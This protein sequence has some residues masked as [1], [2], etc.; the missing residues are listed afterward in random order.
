MGHTHST[1]V[2]TSPGGGAGAV[3]AAA[4][5]PPAPCPPRA[6][7]R[8]L[9][10]PRWR[11]RCLSVDQVASLRTELA[12][13][14]EALAVTF[15][16]GSEEENEKQAEEVASEDHEAEASART[17]SSALLRDPMAE[18]ARMLLLKP[19]EE[20]HL[21]GYRLGDAALTSPNLPNLPSF[22]SAVSRHTRL[23]VLDLSFNNLTPEVLVP[24]LD[25]IRDLPL[26]T[27]LK[28]SGNMF[29]SA[30]SDDDKDSVN[31][32]WD[33][34]TVG[35]DEELSGDATASARLGR[36]LATNP[37]L[38]ELALFHCGLNDRD[39][40]DLL[41]GL[42]HPRNTTLHT[43]QLSWNLAC[44]SRSAAMA[45]QLV[46]DLGN[47]VLRELE[48]EGVA[49]ATQV[50][51]EYA[52]TSDGVFRSGHTL[53]RESAG[54][55]AATGDGDNSSSSSTDTASARVATADVVSLERLRQQQR[56]LAEI[57]KR[58]T[59]AQG[60]RYENR[61][62]YLTEDLDGSRV[63]DPLVVRELEAV[64]STR[65]RPQAP[66]NSHH[67][68]SELSVAAFAEQ[69]M[70]S[71]SASGT[72]AQ[73]PDNSGGEFVM[74]SS[75][76]ESGD[77]DPHSGR[78]V[79][80]PVAIA[81]SAA[82]HERQSFEAA[83]AATAMTH[84]HARR[85]LSSP[86]ATDGPRPHT[87]PPMHLR[88][89]Q[90]QQHHR[91]PQEL[92]DARFETPRR[93][94]AVIADAE[95]FRRR[96]RPM[97]LD[98]HAPPC[99]E[100]SR[101]RSGAH[102]ASAAKGQSLWYAD[103]GF[104]LRPNGLTNVLVAPVL[105]GGMTAFTNVA[106]EDVED[107]SL[108]PCW[109]TP[110]QSSPLT[111]I[112]AGTLHY[113]CVHEAT[114]QQQKRQYGTSASSP[115][116]AAATA[117]KPAPPNASKTRLPLLLS[118]PSQE[119][120]EESLST[121][122]VYRG[123]QGTGHRCLS[124]C[125]ASKEGGA[126]RRRHRMQSTLHAKA[127]KSVCKAA[128]SGPDAPASRRLERPQERFPDWTATENDAADSLFNSVAAA[129]SSPL[130]LSTVRTRC[131]GRSMALSYSPAEHF[132]APHVGCASGMK[133]AEF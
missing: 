110:R 14:V 58:L 68:A 74:P 24:L 31:E 105:P 8:P 60:T 82:R 29:G 102:S 119:Q 34:S 63:L 18:E 116:V 78:A 6:P 51:L 84:D 121:A 125:V 87:S 41:A 97:Q 86:K 114:S 1:S 9:M 53:I 101:T 90:Q 36:Y 92:R 123:C 59:P 126:G 17:L 38:L 55:A 124:A 46:T 80:S 57:Q 43:L 120:E 83:A 66:V 23:R 108:Q 118:Q 62:R 3:V 32:N 49:P 77:C 81:N 72:E 64:L 15:P 111:G 96:L 70:A 10:E 130:R 54:A 122:E 28:L 99:A 132:S 128:V 113:H 21:A 12:R 5:M 33:L 67:S 127:S 13:L 45:L 47:T 104:V 39:V 11:S 73:G 48:L 85:I 79:P 22:L 94:A 44:T 109:C 2:P 50:R 56:Q 37:A 131:S 117:V 106:L 7:N 26:L 71:P 65:S 42:V 91:T 69:E 40:R 107:H 25:A 20:I 93:L 52:C 27:V 75:T 103:D 95:A 30:R 76:E 88:R 89:Q 35:F 129:S 100:V 115:P 16:A 133:L 19:F 61:C 112:F 98:T 4:G